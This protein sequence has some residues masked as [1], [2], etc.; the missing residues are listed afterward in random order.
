M[1][2]NEKATG[3]G[4]TTIQQR[5]AEV[6]HTDATTTAEEMA[7]LLV[8]ARVEVLQGRLEIVEIGGEG[9][10]TSQKNWTPKIQTTTIT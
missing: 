2:R 3:V 1:S 6:I 10:W 4:I 8:T 5:Q 9:R 7:V